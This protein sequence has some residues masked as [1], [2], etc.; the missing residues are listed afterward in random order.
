MR[1]LESPVSLLQCGLQS[2]CDSLV[3]AGFDVIC[4]ATNH[5]MD[6]GRAGLVNCAEYWRDEYPQ[7]TVLAF[8]ILRI[9][10]LPAVQT[11]RSL[12]WETCGLQS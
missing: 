5:A 8:M 10:P 12:S 4:H 11:L 6:K 9:P 1:I 3:G 7:I 2:P